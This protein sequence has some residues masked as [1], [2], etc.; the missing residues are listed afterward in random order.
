MTDD[1]RKL[2]NTFIRSRAGYLTKTMS[3]D[4]I[5]L[6]G[7]GLRFAD[8]DSIVDR[9]DSWGYEH[10]V[11]SDHESMED[12][13]RLGIILNYNR[14][15][16]QSKLELAEDGFI[17]FHSSD[18][19]KGRGWAPIYNTMVRDLPLVQTMLFVEEDVDSGPMIAK[20]KYPLEGIELE[21]EV[22]RIDENLTIAL[23]DSCLR[24]IIETEIQGKSQS[25]E[26]ATYWERRYPEDS[27]VILSDSLESIVDHLRAVPDEAPGF[28]EYRGR[29]F[30][31]EISDLGTSRVEFESGNVS[32]EKFY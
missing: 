6:V 32:L 28:F 31:I 11:F 16:P 21:H 29:K 20:A 15:L 25:D 19:P 13:Y 3:S 12:E 14:I 22:R 27:K 30:A 18:L 10:R 23:I 26:D 8:W 2:T 24:D 9:L 4:T 17:L 7:D 1:G 5:A